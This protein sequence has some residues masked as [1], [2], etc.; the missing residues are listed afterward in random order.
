MISRG[1]DCDNRA[2][3]HSHGASSAQR[4]PPTSVGSPRSPS[5]EVLLGAATDRL[6]RQRACTWAE[7]AGLQLGQGGLTQIRE[8]ALTRQTCHQQRARLHYYHHDA[9]SR[10]DN[11]ARKGT[12]RPGKQGMALCGRAGELALSLSRTCS[13]VADFGVVREHSL[14][15]GHCKIRLRRL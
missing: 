3:D 10:G 6:V 9:L 4:R 15:A 14:V 11:H 7:G 1:A 5:K 8:F 2:D 13:G 12:A